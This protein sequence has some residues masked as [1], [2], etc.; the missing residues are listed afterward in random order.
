M[1][2]SA[3]GLAFVI[4]PGAKCKMP[5]SVNY[6]LLASPSVGRDSAGNA[7]LHLVWSE[8]PK[9]FGVPHELDFVPLG[10]GMVK[11]QLP[12]PEQFL[13]LDIRPLCGFQK[14]QIPSTKLSFNWSAKRAN[15][16][17]RERLASVILTSEE[18]RMPLELILDERR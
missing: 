12:R 3:E 5:A 18:P 8:H 7:V 15:H 1:T 11:Q 10:S 6:R 9:G 2:I 16:R 14:M 17:S 4:A 13:Y